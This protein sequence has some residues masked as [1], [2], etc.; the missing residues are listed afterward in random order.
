[1]KI[2][3]MGLPG[4]GKT[5]LAKCIVEKLRESGKSVSW[6]N[7]DEIRAKY[8]DWDFSNQGRIRQ[9]KRMKNLADLSTDD[10]VI[11]DFVAPLKQMRD[12]FKADFT[13]WMNTI[14]SG[15]FQDTNK[16]FEKPDQV[17]LMIDNINSNYWSTTIYDI[18]K[19]H[20]TKDLV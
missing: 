5:T 19:N 18:L 4:S 12:I 11:V 10:I 3:I 7:A 16:M 6:F 1:M 13:V 14:S 20:Y 9:A 8:D 15:R 17:D 2:L